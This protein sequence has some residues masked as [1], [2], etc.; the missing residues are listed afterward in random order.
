MTRRLRILCADD[1]RIVL[2]TVRRMIE[3]FGHEA[4]VVANGREAVDR[5]G[6]EQPDVVLLDVSMPVMDG[7]DACAEIRRLCGDRWVPVVFLSSASESRDQARGLDAGGDDYLIKPVDPV[8]LAAK[9]RAMARIAD[10]QQTLRD[11]AEA[12]A[13]YR[14]ET[15]E[16]QRLGRHLM[17]RLV[18]VD[19]L[20]GG[21]VRAWIM[22]ALEFS[23]DVVCAA[24]TPSG[25]LHV[26]LAD[27]TGHGLG[28]ALSVMPVVEAFY[29][30]TEKGFWIE[31]LIRRLNSQVKTLLPLGRFVAATV[32]AIDES[33]RTIRVWNGGNPLAVFVASSGVVLCRFESRH[34]AL[35]I[36]GDDRLD[37]TTESYSWTEPGEFFLWSDGL[38]EAENVA[39]E[40]LGL[41]AILST[42]AQVGTTDR[43]DDLVARVQRHLLGQVGQD[44]VS[45]LRVACG[46]SPSFL[47][48]GPAPAPA[49]APAATGDSRLALHVGG[50]N[51]ASADVL[52]V[53]ILWLEQLGVGRQ[54][55]AEFGL[56]VAELL[57]NALDHGVL[58]LESALKA[59][60]DGFARYVELREQR[61]EAL[62]SGA[63]MV[64]VEA[65]VTA[66]ESLLEV[67]VQ[68]T[69]PGF[70]HRRLGVAEAALDAVQQ[71]SGRGMALVRRLCERLEY[72]GTG[73][74]VR[75]VYRLR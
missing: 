32:A 7:Y 30:L 34:P 21:A 17:E 46:T 39:G 18:R 8:L 19:R 40:Q 15:E 72:L 6:V 56:V 41:P 65:H 10:L 4:I 70:D 51:L 42:L 43:F 36:F 20:N 29:D 55:R 64:V 28:A 67:W 5:F 35:G 63:V 2:V 57:T 37:T 58:G 23:G 11:H 71:R 14:A 27:G 13:R 26:L 22:P 54:H 31:T 16:E 50:G 12:L 38:S 62:R 53:V 33:Q 66:D 75:A 61:L 49:E 1:D 48:A 69:G 45:V 60:P 74:E 47:E 25:V 24:R 3:R 9:L 52:P 59:E 44:D 73:N 68:D